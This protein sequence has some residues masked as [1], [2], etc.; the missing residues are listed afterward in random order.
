MKNLKAVK[1]VAMAGLFTCLKVTSFAQVTGI[2]IND[3]NSTADASAML[4]IN[5][6]SASAKKG[7][8]IPRVTTTQRDAISSPATSL[9]VFNTTTARFEYY[10]GTSWQPLATSTTTT[11][12]GWALTGNSGTS[13][14]LNFVGTTDGQA[15]VFKV[16]NT[17][18]GYLGTTSNYATAFGMS[19]VAGYR[20]TALGNSAS[21]LT[22]NEAVALGYNANGNGYQAVAIGSGSQSTS[23]H[24]VAI[25]Y[26]A[27][28][29]SY[30]AIAI[31]ASSRANT[32]SQTIA[33]GVS[34]TAAGYQTT[35]IGA[36]SKANTGDQ[37]LAVGVSSTATGYQATAV[38][39]SSSATGQWASAFGTSASA[40]A[41]NSTA[42]GYGANVGTSNYISIGNGSVQ[43][44]R[45]QVSFTTYSDGRFKRNIHTDVPGL[46]FVSK[47]RPVT[48]TWDIHS[49][50]RYTSNGIKNVG[51]DENEENAM[52]EKE[53]IRYTG[54]IAQEV[55]K[56][57]LESGYD[58]SG[59]LK[60]RNGKDLYSLSYSEFVVPLVKAAQELNE[61]N[62]KL[63]KQLKTQQELIEKLSERLSKLEQK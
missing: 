41:Y 31:G 43:A 26:D 59:V 56:A 55:E 16:N 62:E 39:T 30:E 60:P 17:Q 34:A 53:K 52:A 22:G 2:A 54:F 37:T 32:N 13:E 47:L 14:L 15:L 36:S 46:D 42:I 35:A 21:A 19:A 49:M 28:A 51:Y 18:S 5:V 45:G 3:N 48:Y 12:S 57:A 40:S 1:L 10:T 25:A 27:Q 4:D 63:E 29:T 11:S 58:F 38:G 50:N 8:L 24:N 44:I 20:A 33:I 7:I 6:N 9:L 61:K 23:N